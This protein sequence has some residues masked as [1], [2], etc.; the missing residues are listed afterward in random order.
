VADPFRNLRLYWHRARD[1]QAVTLAGVTLR[2]GADQARAVR[3][4]LFKRTYEAPEQHLL[5]RAVR[6]G[7][8]VL[9]VG[10][11]IGFIG[12]L[13]ARLAG[14]AGRVVSYEA[15]PR[16]KPVI[17][18]NYAL[19]PLNPE[20]RMR[21]ITRDG[22]PVSFHVSDNVVSSSLYHRAETQSEV[23]VESDSLEA[24][25]ADVAP[26]VLVMDVE[27]AEVDLLA[28]GD[29]APVRCA[30]I[31]L[32]PHI[33]GEARITALLESLEQRGL[34]VIARLE[35]NVLIERREAP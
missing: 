22:A 21:A 26:D 29:L 23:T 32:H 30:V 14:Q 7:D 28:E 31:E 10:A 11:G 8:R 25:L 15:N 5:Q 13:S 35:K 1:T 19:N 18:A 33:V 17:E 20:L 27:G 4:G 16:L 2:S 3:N 34:V 6:P 9:E 12:L 24:A